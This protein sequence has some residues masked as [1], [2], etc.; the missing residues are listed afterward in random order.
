VQPHGGER[1]RGEQAA[2]RDE[3]YGHDWLPA[4]PAAP[5]PRA[6]RPDLTTQALKLRALVGLQHA[7]A[8][9]LGLLG[10]G[11]PSAGFLARASDRRAAPTSPERDDLG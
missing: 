9:A 1:D 2:Q 6:Q 7:R 10:H 5:V 11:R 3:N 4:H 8:L